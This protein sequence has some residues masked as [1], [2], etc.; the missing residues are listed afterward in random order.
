MTFFWKHR[1]C[2]LGGVLLCSTVRECPGAL[3]PRLCSHLWSFVSGHFPQIPPGADGSPHPT[4]LSHCFGL[5][6]PKYFPPWRV[7]TSPQQAAQQDRIKRGGGVWG[8]GGGG[9]CVSAAFCKKKWKSLSIKGVCA[10]Y[11]HKLDENNRTGETLK[12]FFFFYSFW[13]Q[14]F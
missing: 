10:Q 4:T 8:G 12:Y 2:V 11:N 5:P 9:Y 6:F 14:G 3:C 7:C 1:T 13:M